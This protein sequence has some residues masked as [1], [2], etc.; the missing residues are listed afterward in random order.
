MCEK[1]EPGIIVHGYNSLE[2][3]GISIVHGSGLSNQLMVKEVT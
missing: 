3:G 2:G 1:N